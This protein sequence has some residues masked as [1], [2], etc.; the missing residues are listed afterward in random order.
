MILEIQQ[1]LVTKE[2]NLANLKILKNKDINEL[3]SNPEL[4]D[5][6]LNFSK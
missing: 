3:T 4:M 5:L 1:S 2:L 6:L